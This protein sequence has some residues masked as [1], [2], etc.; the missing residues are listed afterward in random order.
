MIK[1]VVIFFGIIVFLFLVLLIRFI[2][3][4]LKSEKH[5]KNF[6]FDEI[7]NLGETE[8]LEILPIVDWDVSHEALSG[9]A[10]VSYLI[11]LDGTNILF[12]VGYNPRK[13]NPSPLLKNMEILGVNLDNID[14]IVISHNHPDHVGGIKWK[15]R[16]TFSIA[17]SQI[18]LKAK[19][20]YTP[21]KMTYPGLN[22]S[23]TE[24][25]TLLSNAVAT[26]GVIRNQC[27]FLGSIAEQALAINVK[28]KGIVL[29]VGCGHQTVPKIIERTK[30]V[31]GKPI[32][33]IVGGL[34]FPVS[35][36]RIKVLGLPVQKFIGTCRV[37][38]RGIALSEAEDS[39]SLLKREGIKKVVLSLHDSCDI[40]AGKFQ[41]TYGNDF[42]SIKIGDRIMF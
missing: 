6:R 1:N 29:V 35:E 20:V 38:W 14:S 8:Y 18:D 34:H 33:A 40:V 15:Q 12:D 21:E 37:P 26:I 19:K 16:K 42:K 3:G 7:H 27:F 9:E 36:S 22:P 41:K 4:K 2:I 13:I 31:F 39:I 28:G 30:K 5:W 32:Y 10:G 11:R 17:P 24:K 23:F 25:P